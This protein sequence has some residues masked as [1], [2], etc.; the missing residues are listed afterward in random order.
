MSAPT[1]TIATVNAKRHWRD[2]AG[3]MVQILDHLLAVGVQVFTVNEANRAQVR[4]LRKD[5]RVSIARATPN[6]RFPR[7]NDYV[8]NVV[9]WVKADFRRAGVPRQMVT[10]W[11]YPLHAP[12]V[13]LAHRESGTIYKHLGPHNP[14]RTAAA[15]SARRTAE[16]RTMEHRQRRWLRRQN[17]PAAVAGD[18]NNGDPWPKA[19]RKGLV[20]RAARNGPDTIHVNPEHLTRVGGGVIRLKALRL[21]DHN[22]VFAR[23]RVVA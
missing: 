10:T 12:M 11:R 8:C 7:R 15:V 16:R 19:R 3:R 13:R 1:F 22:A 14:T 2:P 6:N 21:S 4:A 17:V 18:L 23:V 5:P 9:V 20:T